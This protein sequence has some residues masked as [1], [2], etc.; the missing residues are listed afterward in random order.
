M[1]DDE[2]A[3]TFAQSWKQRI[4][5]T[6]GGLQVAARRRTA[7]ARDASGGGRTGWAS[8]EA[9]TL[10]LGG[11]LLSPFLASPSR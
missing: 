5:W 4:R 3:S 7:A 10:S 1:L 8:F 2:Q 9:A 11:Y 6:Q